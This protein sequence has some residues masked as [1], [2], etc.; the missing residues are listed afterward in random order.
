MKKILI[1]LS[2]ICSLA[3]HAGLGKRPSEEQEIQ[4]KRIHRMST[5][6]A[7]I[8]ACVQYDD[9]D[10]LARYFTPKT[11]NRPLTIQRDTLMHVGAQ[12]NKPR[13]LAFALSLGALVSIKNRHRE[14][15]LHIAAR[16]QAKDAFIFLVTQGGCL[17]TLDNNFLTPLEIFIA[18]ND[19]DNILSEHDQLTLFNLAAM[20]GYNFSN[21]LSNNENGNSLL[22]LAVDFQRPRI[23]EFLLEHGHPFDCKDKNGKTPLM[24]AIEEKKI[25]EAEMLLKTQTRLL[26]RPTLP[27]GNVD[28]FGDT[29]FHYAARHKN[30]RFLELITSYAEHPLMVINQENNAKERPLHCAAKAYKYETCILLLRYGAP[31]NAQDQYGDTA[32][33]TLLKDYR[34]FRRKMHNL[35]P[36]ANIL[37]KQRTAKI[38][39]MIE[40][41]MRYQPNLNIAN[42][43]GLRLATSIEKTGLIIPMTFLF[44]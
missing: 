36:S 24:L 35:S 18:A 28:I 1:F 22:H 41:M 44:Q 30:S 21:A 23:I 19:D 38:S 20:H 32:L 34:Y 15:P 12:Y 26:D 17:N 33:H 31:I 42:A 11:I 3:L 6:Y 29:V 4:A 40:S 7:A 2:S 9:I 8:L 14:H 13:V 37:Y 16:N 10:A 5:D 43:S 27:L 39:A 25:H